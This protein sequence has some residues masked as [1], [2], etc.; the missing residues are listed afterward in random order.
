M[1]TFP[2]STTIYREKQAEPCLEHRNNVQCLFYLLPVRLLVYKLFFWKQS[3]Q[4]IFHL[5]G[6]TRWF[7]VFFFTLKQILGAT[8]LKF[9]S[10]RVGRRTH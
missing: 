8:P 7:Y 4:D 9:S 5:Q 2:V 10:N 3:I 6:N 1:N